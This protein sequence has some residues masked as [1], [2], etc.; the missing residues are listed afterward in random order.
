MARTSDAGM[1]SRDAMAAVLHDGDR[2]G[3]R[4]ERTF[5]HSPDK[6]WRA[7]TEAEH[8]AH[9]MPCDIV[10]ER[11]VGA[12][13]SMPFWPAVAEKFSITGPA[14]TGM[15]LVWNPPRCFAFS[16]DTD[17]VRFDLAPAPAGGTVLTL[18]TWIGAV[19]P[20]PPEVASGYHLCLAHLAQV[21]DTGTA[22]NVATSDPAPLH[23]HYLRHWDALDHRTEPAP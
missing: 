10:G 15:L 11:T 22:P 23:D 1:N 19:E 14:P 16:W 6:V 20:P 4:F 3:L 8:L 21:V 13:L 9:W 12:T 18:T 17:H 5:G 7:I 2:V